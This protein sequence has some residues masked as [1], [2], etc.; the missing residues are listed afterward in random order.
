MHRLGVIAVWLGIVLA[1]AGLAIGFT[2]LMLGKDELGGFW[3]GLIPIGFLVLLSGV[4]MTQL[5]HK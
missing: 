3:L 5:S 4:V 2:G 1:V